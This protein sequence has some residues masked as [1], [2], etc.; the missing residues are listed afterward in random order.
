MCS[1]NYRAAA[2][3]EKGQ[4]RFEGAPAELLESDDIAPAVFLGAAATGKR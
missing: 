4:V 1:Q 2:F 3:L